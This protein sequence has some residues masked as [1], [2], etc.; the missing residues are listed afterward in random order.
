MFTTP[1][2]INV[3]ILGGETPRMA[4]VRMPS[5]QQWIE[6]Q[7]KRP[8]EVR[9]L[10]R[11]RSETKVRECR[12][13]DLRI[14]NEIRLDG[15]PD[16]DQYEA[17]AILSSLARA[18]MVSVERREDG[19]LVKIQT[20]AGVFAPILKGPSAKDGQI[21]AET[22]SRILNKRGVEEIFINLNAGAVLFDSCSMQTYSVPIIWKA[23]AAAVLLDEIE[24]G[25]AGDD[26]E[27]LFPD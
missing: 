6:R 13:E 7:R 26:Q 25:F 5:D 19:Y 9:Q 18:E 8:I 21:Y 2:Q 24:A 20:V 11:G 23:A 10:G 1:E 27:D 16:L 22:R 12:E 14:Y 3:Q 4:T 17:S 15:S